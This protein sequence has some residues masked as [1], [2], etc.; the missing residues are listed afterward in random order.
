MSAAWL[1][2][3]RLGWWEVPQPATPEAAAVLGANPPCLP[4]SSTLMFPSRL[5][6]STCMQVRLDRGAA[7]AGEM[8]NVDLK[9]GDAVLCC[10]RQ[11]FPC[12]A[13]LAEWRRKE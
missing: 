6:V 11:C 10:C 12:W 5:C 4:V 3:Q 9:V 8:I 2:A 7:S 1:W 13:T